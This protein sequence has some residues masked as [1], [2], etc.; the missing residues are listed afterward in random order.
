MMPLKCRERAS[1]TAP[2]A[3]GWSGLAPTYMKAPPLHGAHPKR[4]LKSRS[5][6]ISRHPGTNARHPRSAL[7]VL[8]VVSG[9]ASD[10]QRAP[11]WFSSR[12]CTM[13]A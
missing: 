1:M 8:N 2:I 11:P 7:D 13:R 12:D 10:V 4:A 5:E 9:R 3:C 6:T